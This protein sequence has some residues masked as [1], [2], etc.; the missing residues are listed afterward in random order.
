M[1]RHIDREQLALEIA[2]ETGVAITAD[3]PIMSLIKAHDIVLDCYEKRWRECTD[4]AI[5]RIERQANAMVA[6]VLLSSLVG[7]AYV[8]FLVWIVP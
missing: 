6:V 8:S 5:R 1:S 3:D 2:R 4:K 7:F